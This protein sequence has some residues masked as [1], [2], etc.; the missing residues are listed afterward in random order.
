[1]ADPGRFEV[2][3]GQLLGRRLLGAF[4]AVLLATLAT[5]LC[6]LAP[7]AAAS[8]PSTGPNFGYDSPHPAS[9]TPARSE[10]APSESSTQYTLHDVADH[11]SRGAS[12]C[13]QPG[14]TWPYYDYDRPVR[15]AHGDRD[16]VTTL[17]GSG[18]H[19]GNMRVVSG[20]RVAAMSA[21]EFVNIASEARTTHILYGDA[22][23]GG[24]LWPGLPGKTAFPK[25]WSADRVMHEISDVATDP[26]SIFRP[27]RGGSTVVTGTR[28]GVDIRVILRNGDIV[29]GYPT[30]L[31]RN[32]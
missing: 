27:G 28:D 25:D 5:W 4:V 8:A 24:H 14:S 29:T 26:S 9:V 21:D 19:A 3:A 1:M 32:P 23:G 7:A 16:W 20:A 10:A 31:P 15:F 2:S 11:G 12:A 17:M 13:P 6:S 18:G 22:T 30:N